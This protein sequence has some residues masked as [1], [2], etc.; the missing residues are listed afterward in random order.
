MAR[1]LRWVVQYSE[2]EKKRKC[3]TL[4]KEKKRKVLSVYVRWMYDNNKVNSASSPTINKVYLPSWW[5]TNNPQANGGLF[6]RLWNCL[7]YA[8]THSSFF[9]PPPEVFW[10]C[11]FW[12]WSKILG[13]RLCVCLGVLVLSGEN[14]VSCQNSSAGKAHPETENKDSVIITHCDCFYSSMSQ[15]LLSMYD[16]FVMFSDNLWGNRNNFKAGLCYCV[17]LY[18]NH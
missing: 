18:L 5:V 14:S 15:R 12:L 16:V 9:F 6:R 13:N 3:S 4:T 7:L 17:Q 10:F 8:H 2:E 1:L 11:F